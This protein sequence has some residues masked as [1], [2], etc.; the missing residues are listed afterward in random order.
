MIDR[1]Y[2]RRMARYNAWQN[3]LL[4]DV[5]E[6]MP[7]ADI[8]KDL[9]MEHGSLL[10]ALNHLLW[11]DRMWLSRLYAIDR[12]AQELA[13]STKMTKD[14]RGWWLERFRAD[15]ALRM[16]AETLKSVDLMDQ[17]AFWS[18]SLEEDIIL[19]K[20]TCIMHMFNQQ[21]DQRAVIRSH[22]AAMGQTLPRVN[23]FELPPE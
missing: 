6:P 21:T 4:W 23:L 11:L 18:I 22:L 7:K 12:P 9:P 19:D 2:C 20:A 5:I 1:A 16:W 17:I 14:A 8:T 13:E 15:G 3:K 10:G